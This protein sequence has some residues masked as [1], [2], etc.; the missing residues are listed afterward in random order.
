M[1][2]TSTTKSCRR[3][4]IDLRCSL[5]TE[6]SVSFDGVKSHQ[7]SRLGW[8]RIYG[9]VWLLLM[10]KGGGRV[11]VGDVRRSLVC[12]ARLSKT[13]GVFCNLDW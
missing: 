11:A 10:L 8:E 3:D 2:I 5:N 13:L 12:A 7:D 6:I 4:I 1:S 9:L